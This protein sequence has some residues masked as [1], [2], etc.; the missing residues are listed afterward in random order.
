MT[1][2][3]DAASTPHRA[4][5]GDRPPP[6]GTTVPAGLRGRTKIATSVIE[7]IVGHVAVQ[8]PGVSAAALTGVRG[9]LGSDRPD[10]AAT[11]VGRSGAGVHVALQVA[12]TYPHPIE[13]VVE[14][15]RTRVS[16]AL[17]AQMAVEVERVDITITE[18][19]L[20]PSSRFTVSGN[21][22]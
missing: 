5:S 6:P 19:R 20:E 16:T 11:Q 12:V 17:D 1:I 4:D 3:L 18:L 15:L 10:G 14:Q 8:T 7:K 13:L 2:L 22:P 9:W 21:R